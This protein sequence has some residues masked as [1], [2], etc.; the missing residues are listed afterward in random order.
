MRSIRS[1][2]QFPFRATLA[3][4]AIAAVVA[5]ICLNPV[6]V[7]ADDEGPA[8][9]SVRLANETIAKLLSSKV[10]ANSAAEKRLAHRVTTSVRDLLDIDALGQH[11]LTDHWS[12]LTADQRSE[13][14]GLLR[15]LIEDSYVRGLRAQIN[16]KILY[17]GEANKGD[18]ILVRTKIK[19]RRR[20]RPYTISV[21]YR[22]RKDGNRLR[23]FDVV[24]DGVGLVENYRA[25]FNKIIA[26]EGFEG[27]LARMKR[28]RG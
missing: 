11:A 2:P 17:I 22:I 27:L 18:V 16:Y 6:S 28:K 15:G 9:R 4:V 25:Q 1:I 3:T 20:G 7:L 14:L 19:S 5:S 26:K 10:K 24:T 21:D 12:T 23:A 8:T 13:F